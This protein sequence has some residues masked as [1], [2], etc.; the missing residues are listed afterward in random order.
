MKKWFQYIMSILIAMQITTT[1][2]LPN[3]PEETVSRAEPFSFC[4]TA[5]AAF[6]DGWFQEEATEITFGE[7]YGGVSSMG[8]EFSDKL[9]RQ[10][11]KRVTMTGFM[12]PPLKPTIHFFVL[13]REP[14]SICPFCSS[15]ADWPSDI[16]V[17]EVAEPIVALPFDRPIQVSGV[18]E[19]GTAVDEETGFVSLV[20]IKADT[21]AESE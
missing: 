6:W 10:E 15:D 18:L 20:R 3:L 1:F 19:L 9:T 21:L 8:I 16:V 4:Q 5:Y 11:G 2:S 13:T 12:A 14:M 17:V 7:M